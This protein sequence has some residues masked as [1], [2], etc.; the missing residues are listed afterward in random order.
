MDEAAWLACTDPHRLLDEATRCVSH[1]K[2]ILFACS[3]ARRAWDLVQDAGDLGA[4][5]AL[6]G[7][8]EP[9]G[10]EPGPWVR[11]IVS[12]TRALA[13]AARRFA[14]TPV[15]RYDPHPV[16]ATAVSD[17]AVAS[18]IARCASRVRTG[19][20]LKALRREE[21]RVQRILLRDVAGNPFRTPRLDDGWRKGNEG[22]AEKLAA[23]A[24]ESRSFGN[25]RI[26][27]DALEEAGFTDQDIL[28]HLRKHGPH[29]RGCWVVDLVLGRK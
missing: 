27:A 17:V 22:M 3:C 21:R 20:P 1:R 14:E 10:G 2:L 19:R 26:L 13:G 25:M 18:R 28:G 4:L 6:E 12:V 24:Y 8:A 7:I 29:T 5:D 9:G 15:V 11:A 23:G 16:F